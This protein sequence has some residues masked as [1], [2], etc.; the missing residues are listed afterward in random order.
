VLSDC[1]DVDDFAAV[2]PGGPGLRPR[3]RVGRIAGHGS[4]SPKLSGHSVKRSCIA[5]HY[6]LTP[7]PE[8]WG[9]NRVPYDLALYDLISPYLLRGDTFGKWHAALSVIYVAEHTVR[10]CQLGQRTETLVP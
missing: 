3:L 8:C 1:S 6:P 10:H 7:S 5:A 9:R 2:A 4:A